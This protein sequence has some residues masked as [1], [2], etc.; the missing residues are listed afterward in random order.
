MRLITTIALLSAVLGANAAQ[1]PKQE[2]SS[3]PT[4]AEIAAEKSWALTSGPV[5]IGNGNYQMTVKVASKTCKT[6][7]RPI[8]GE[9]GP[10]RWNVT[11]INCAAQ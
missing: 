7:M 11:A 10:G 1:P 5:S 2:A 9:T 8:P 4:A 6:T 3:A